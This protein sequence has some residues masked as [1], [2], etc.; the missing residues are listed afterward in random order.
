MAQFAS[1]GGT[2]ENAN[3]V[4]AVKQ[5]QNFHEGGW[6]DSKS[7]SYMDMVNKYY[8][9]STSFYEVRCL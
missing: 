2:G 6:N 3:V 8:D 4:D 7:V 5:Y 9:L 1:T